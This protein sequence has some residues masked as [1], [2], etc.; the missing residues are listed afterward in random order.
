MW[1]RFCKDV[2][3]EEN[4]IPYKSWE[5]LEQEAK[6]KEEKIKLER[7][8][9][10]ERKIYEATWLQKKELEDIELLDEV[11]QKLNHSPSEAIYVL[12]KIMDNSPG[13]YSRI[14]NYLSTLDDEGLW[15]PLKTEKGHREADELLRTLKLLENSLEQQ[16]L[17]P[18]IEENAKLKK[19]DNWK[20]IFDN[21]GEEFAKIVYSDVLNM[22]LPEVPKKSDYILGKAFYDLEGKMLELYVEKLNE[23]VYNTVKKIYKFYKIPKNYIWFGVGDGLYGGYQE[24]KYTIYNELEENNK[25]NGKITKEFDLS[26]TEGLKEFNKFMSKRIYDIFKKGFQRNKTNRGEYYE[27]RKFVNPDQAVKAKKT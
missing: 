27:I 10:R 21:D 3:L 5:D 14:P 13:T 25:W 12:K 18:K 24:V 22:S 23:S 15:K 4:N 6:Q 17:E 11:W 20:E 1:Y 26:S 9:E 8:Q 7:E 16:A 19:I 2:E